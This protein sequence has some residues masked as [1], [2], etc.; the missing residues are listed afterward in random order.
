MHTSINSRT[1][2]KL[3]VVAIL[4]LASAG[5]P[6]WLE[7]WARRGHHHPHDP[8]VVAGSGAAG[9]SGAPSGGV[10]GFGGNP[11]E[12]VIPRPR[13]TCPRLATSTIK[14]QGLTLQLWVGAPQPNR[15][16]SMVVYW[17]G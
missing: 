5:C 12:P 6:G 7:A 8:P 10:G 16:G 13:G 15:A 1:L 17:H 14:F 9:A 11:A 4:A 3:S 2:Y